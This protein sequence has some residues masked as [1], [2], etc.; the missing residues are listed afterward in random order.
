MEISEQPPVDPTKPQNEEIKPKIEIESKPSLLKRIGGTVG[1]LLFLLVFFE[2]A[3]RIFFNIPIFIYMLPFDDAFE[4]KW[5]Y[6]WLERHKNA[7]VEIYFS[8]DD[9][10]ET[11][12]W[13]S[14]PNLE[15]HSS[16]IDQTM[17]STNSNR[18][19]MTY[20]VPYENTAGNQR[21]LVLGDSFTF[22]ENVNDDENYP[23]LLDQALPDTTVIN[24][25]VHGYGHD[26]M[27]IYF[28]EDG[29][30]YSPDIVMVGFLSTD[31]SRNVLK[32]RDFAK[33]KF[34][35]N[36]GELELTNVPVPK[37]NEVLADSY[38][39]SRTMDVGQIFYDIFRQRTGR[40]KAEEAEITT[41]ILD[42][43]VA[44]TQ[45]I[46]AI[47][48]LVYMPWGEEITED[49]DLVEWEAFMLSYCEQNPEVHCT[50]LRPEFA[51]GLAAGTTFHEGHWKP[52]GHQVVAD[53]VF[54]FLV[55]S[56]LV[57]P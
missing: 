45:E 21:I 41:A 1:Y 42:E 37:P 27:L 11:L 26:Q 23:Y 44:T 15:A 29:V 9:Y 19:R 14:K 50:T 8:Y 17:L 20:D 16:D 33:P 35:L 22:G 53:G 47:P 52:P 51:D 30:K 2:I 7:G 48:V 6:W 43:I 25:G 40:L 3:F 31:V 28:Q 49:L 38:W 18:L 55:K 12:G 57:N 56:E 10:D 36:D 54:D 24:A 13:V 46:G 34:E 4:V 39:R 32:F 5:Y